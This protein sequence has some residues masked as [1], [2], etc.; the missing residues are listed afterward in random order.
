[1]VGETKKQALADSLKHITPEM[2]E[3]LRALKEWGTS[4]SQRQDFVWH[5]LL[6]SFA[7]STLGTLGIIPKLR[8][9]EYRGYGPTLL[10]RYIRICGT[11]P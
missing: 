2:W 9:P 11:W 1:M 5:F 3:Q 4:E 7:I 6:Q 8:Y 10:S